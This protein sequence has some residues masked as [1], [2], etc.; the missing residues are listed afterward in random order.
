MPLRQGQIQ[1]VVV[2]GGS[3]GGLHAAMVL[4]TKLP[5]THRVLLIERNTHFNHLYVFPRFSIYPGHEHKAFVPYTSV[6]DEAKPRRKVDARRPSFGAVPL[7][8]RGINNMKDLAESLDTDSS[9]GKTSVACMDDIRHGRIVLGDGGGDGDADGSSNVQSPEDDERAYS[10]AEPHVVLHASVVGITPSHV[11]VRD[12]HTTKSSGLWSIDT[13]DIPY[14]HLIYALGS[15]MPDP[16]RL[17]TCT[18]YEGVEMMRNMQERIKASRD[19][20]VVGGGALGVQMASDIATLHKGLDKHV[21]LIHS[22]Q[23]LL[24]A[25]DHKVHDEAL[26][27]LKGLGVNVVLG[28]RL[29]LADGCPMGSAVKGAGAGTEEAFAT[30]MLSRKMED[31]PTKRHHI[32]TTHGLEL[33]CDLLLLCTGQRPNTELMARM[34]PESVDPS[35]RLIRVLPT[36][37]VM[38]P[39]DPSSVPRPFDVVPPCRD[40]DCFQDQKLFPLEADH[41]SP[42]PD[43]FSRIYAIGDCVDA[44]GAI[45]AGYQAWFMG[46]VA[47]ENIIKDITGGTSSG[48]DSSASSDS[49]QTED[50]D[51]F[52][53]R[54]NLIKLTVGGGKCVVQGAPEETEDGKTHVP[55]SVQDDAEDMMIEAVWKNMARADPTDMHA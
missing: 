50:L 31:G 17:D 4:A 48:S 40:C 9:R 11:T 39:H 7:R 55:V 18:K 44:F 38:I 12:P 28:Q 26:K 45:N 51:H 33:D 15:H 24:P 27:S 29:A 6:F 1:N 49:A 30:G 10:A 35:T 54:P 36:M 16:L 23:Y 52:H 14:S 37:Q 22:R 19:I 43:V 41:D 46:E 2:L 20:I 47:A 13:V 32:R 53:P 3:Y 42:P 25:F 8:G 5:P 34:S 21:T